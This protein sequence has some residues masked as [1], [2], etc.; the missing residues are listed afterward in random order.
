MADRYIFPAIFYPPEQEGL[1]YCVVSPG[2]D[3]AT[4]GYMVDQALDMAKELL[5]LTIFGLEEDGEPVPSASDPASIKVDQPGA[6]ITLV[7][8]CREMIK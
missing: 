7:A 3:V 8:V 1:D 6:F 4:Q 2:F 5:E